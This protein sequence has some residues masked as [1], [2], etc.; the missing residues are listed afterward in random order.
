VPILTS[1]NL[2]NSV[3]KLGLD[4]TSNTE[5]VNNVQEAETQELAVEKTLTLN[6][7]T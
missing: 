4:S 1:K 6:S 7:I 2:K 5:S 3:N